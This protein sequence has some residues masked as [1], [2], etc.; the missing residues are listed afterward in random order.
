VGLA[1]P[2]LVLGAL[3]VAVLVTVVAAERVAGLRREAR[4]DPSP[5]ERLA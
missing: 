3:V 4:G 5:L 1:V 2:G